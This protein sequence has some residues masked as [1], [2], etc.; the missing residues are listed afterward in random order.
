MFHRSADFLDSKTP[1]SNRGN[2]KLNVNVA[3]PDV[4]ASLSFV[5]TIPSRFRTLDSF[6]SFNIV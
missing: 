2:L 6:N 1:L 3:T 4:V 5:V